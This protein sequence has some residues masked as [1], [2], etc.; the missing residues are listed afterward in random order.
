[1]HLLEPEWPAPA[2]VRAACSTR[3]GGVSRGP[4]ASLNLGDHVGDDAV[5][6]AA[7]RERWAAGIGAAP[8]FLRQVHGTHVV[9]LGDGADEAVTETAD[10]CVSTRKG[11]A[12]TILVADCLPVL[13]CDTRG[14]AVAAAHAGWRGL[15]GVASQPGAAGSV[16][17]GILDT[18]V[19]AFADVLDGSPAEAAPGLMAWLGPCIG[20]QAFEV[21]PE[22]KAAFECGDPAAGS[23]FRPHGEGKWLADLP[24]L[25][26]RRLARLG[27]TSVHGNDG[28]PDW[29][30]VGNPSRFFSY[31]RDGTCGRFGASIWLA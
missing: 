14:R 5:L 25:A 27:V 13:L 3:E 8:R 10:A 12:C 6:V 28:G 24:G 29:C 7:N 26:R 1:M 4:Y 17:Q 22:V 30:T 11:V 21:G 18:V 2:A 15:A 31:R 20:P 9:R 23:L 19:H 16:S